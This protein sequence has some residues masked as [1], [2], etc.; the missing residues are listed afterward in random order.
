M[1]IAAAFAGVLSA[2][3]QAAAGD[4]GQAATVAT[5]P[6]D[7]EKPSYFTDLW[8]LDRKTRDQAGHHLPPIQ[9]RPRRLVHLQPN[10]LPCRVD[11]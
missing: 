4:P 1:V 11:P 5:K 8:Q 7:E 2:S 10:R 9:L 6:A 3:P